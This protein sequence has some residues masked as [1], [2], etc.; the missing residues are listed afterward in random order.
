MKDNGSDSDQRLPWLTRLAD[1]MVLCPSTDPIDTK[2]LK[3]EIIPTANGHLEA[4]T[5]QTD[6]EAANRKI[7]LIKFPGNA[8]RAERSTPNPAQFWERA[9]SQVW[10]INPFGYGGS[11]GTATLQRT[12]E[13]AQAVFSFLRPR[14]PDHKIVVYGNSL[15]SL[16]ALMMAAQHPVDGLYLRNP[17][18]IHSLISTRLRYALP[19]LGM[20][21]LIANQIPRSLDAVAN[22]K[23]IDAPC[24]F[25]TSEKDRMIPPRFQS[26]IIDS[27]AGD[28]QVF[29]IPD[30]DH[31]D[32][33]PEELEHDYRASLDWLFNKLFQ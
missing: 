20:S 18:P 31:H 14:F 24:L 7:L 22:A 1:R 28:H 19:S 8:G 6:T 23:T 9:A 29:L 33:I 32:S 13:M 2:E 3:R 30:A 27:F 10:T 17:V 5:C 12:P 11:S 16:A 25:V 15:G 26:Q 21:R 4:W